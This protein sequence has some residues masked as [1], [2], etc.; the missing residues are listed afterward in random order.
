MRFLHCSDVHVTSAD[1]FSRRVLSLGWRRWIALYKLKF[2]GREQDYQD[3]ADVLRQIAADL[4]HHAA[5]HLILSGDLTAYAREEEFRGCRE[6]LGA[7]VDDPR[8][9]TVIPGNHDTY[10]PD[11][12]EDRL[13]ERYFGHLLQSDFPEYQ[14]EG[15]YP[16]VR[17]FPQDQV[18]VVG[19]LSARVPIVPGA[20]WGK[21]GQAQLEG[22]KALIADPRL[23]NHA[24]LVAVHHAP[25]TESGAADMPHHRLVDVEQLLRLLPGPRFALLH[26]HIHHRYHHPASSTRPHIFGAGSSTQRGRQGYWVIEVKQG[27][28]QGA[29]MFKPGHQEILPVPGYEAPGPL[30]FG[31]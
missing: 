18:A 5:D 28:I 30:T 19:L 3:A 20:S 23:A 17:H 11:A 9:A 8:R 6:A 27:R 4:R 26:G 12:V 13:F 22:L 14:R 1:Y 24:F 29:Q 21:V 7:A 16:L 25:L 10:T 31:P 15:A 2:G